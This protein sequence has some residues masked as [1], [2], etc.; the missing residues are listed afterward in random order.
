MVFY[1]SLWGFSLNIL[2]PLFIYFP[3]PAPLLTFPFFITPTAFSVT[4]LTLLLTGLAT[5]LPFYSLSDYYFHIHH[6][7]FSMFLKLLIVV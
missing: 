5:F 3:V 6:V 1:L 2:S 7:C 4:P